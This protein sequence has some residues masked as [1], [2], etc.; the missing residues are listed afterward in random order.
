MKCALRPVR[1]MGVV[2]Y[3]D[4]RLS[5]ITIQSLQQI[6]DFVAGLTI[7]ITRRLIAQQQRWIRYN[8]A[9]NSNAL[10]LTAR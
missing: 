6:E 8:R 1:R 5:E 7:K 2:G 3:H 4:N 10:L 9:C